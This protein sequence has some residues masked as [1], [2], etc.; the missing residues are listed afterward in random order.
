MVNFNKDYQRQHSDS[1]KWNIYPDDIIPMWVADADY[2]VP[3]VIINALKERLSHPVLGYGVES[4]KLCHLITERMEKCYHWKIKPEWIC[5]VPGVV[6]SLNACRAIMGDVGSRAITALPV[7]PHL[8]NATP[9]LGRE[10][11]FYSMINNRGRFTPDFEELE[12]NIDATTKM[13]ILCNPHNPVGT[14]YNNDELQRFAA[15]AEKHN[16]LICSDDIHADFALYEDKPYRPIAALSPNVSK[17]TMTLMAASKTFNIA[18]LNCS[19]AIIEDRELRK[20]FKT[21]LK[22]L[23]GGVNILGFVATEAAYEYGEDWLTEQLEHLRK[24]AEYC[25]QRIQKMP[26]LSMNKLEATFLAWINATTANVKAKEKGFTNFHEYLLS[27][28]IAV[29]DGKDFGDENFIRINLAT[30]EDLL[31]EGLN[32][33]EKAVRELC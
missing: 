20:Q 26:L 2:A 7:Y 6:A 3:E 33:L 31:S 5:F 10:M 8:Q 14:V 28:G 25:Y 15:I 32:R 29:S 19:Y 12:S 22:G 30:S 13:L 24:N 11:I 23:V 1:E 21:Q 17:R 9:I 4:K 16:L 18:G 27:F